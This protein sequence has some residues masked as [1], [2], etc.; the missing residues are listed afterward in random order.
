MCISVWSLGSLRFLVTSWPPTVI[1]DMIL[2]PMF[3]MPKGFPVSILK[4]MQLLMIFKLSPVS[5]SN[6][7]AESFSFL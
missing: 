7:A 1:I 4:V 5:V 6:L 2:A 3:V